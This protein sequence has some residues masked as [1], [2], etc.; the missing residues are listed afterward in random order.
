MEIIVKVTLTAASAAHTKRNSIPSLT[1]APV[2]SIPIHI[3][4]TPQTP[5]QYPQSILNPIQPPIPITK[6]TADTKTRSPN[7]S[8]Y[9]LPPSSH[10]HHEPPQ[11]SP[12][13]PPHPLSSLA[14]WAVVL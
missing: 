1:I 14:Q 2:H 6:Q 3:T 12:S 8:P 10:R 4:H 13:D 7:P 5:C 11:T 9:S